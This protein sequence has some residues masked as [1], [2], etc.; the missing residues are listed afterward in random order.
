MCGA[1]ADGCALLQTKILNR[2]LSCVKSDHESV[3]K[4]ALSFLNP[5]RSLLLRHKND[6]ATISKVSCHSHPIR[7]LRCTEP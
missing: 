1:K 2:V 4:A 5:E 3:V 6:P 7:L